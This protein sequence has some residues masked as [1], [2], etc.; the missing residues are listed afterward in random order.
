[1]F[2]FSDCHSVFSVSSVSS[3]NR[4]I[5]TYLSLAR[6][7]R[8]QSFN[9]LVGQER[10][11]KAL[12]SSLRLSRIPQALIFSGVRGVG[13][14]TLARLYAKALCC[15]S[16]PTPDPCG[17]CPNCLAIGNGSHGDVCEIDAASHNGVD[18]IRQLQDS[19]FYAP[20]RSAYRV[21]ILDEVHMLSLSAFNALLKTLEEP[22][23]HVVFIFATTDPH[24]IPDTILGRCQIFH[25]KKITPEAILGRV[26]DILGREGI[27]F[28]E[29]ALFPIA[30]KAQ[31]SMR[32]ALTFLDQAIALGGGEVRL[33]SVLEL[34]QGISS[35]I[36]M[37]WL[38]ELLEGQSQAALE[39]IQAWENEGQNLLPVTE[40]LLRMIRNSFILKNENPGGQ[41]LIS[42]TSKELT[43]LKALVEHQDPKR[44]RRMFQFFFPSL[45]DLEGSEYDRFILENLCLEWCFL[46]EDVIPAPQATLTPVVPP[47]LDPEPLEPREAPSQE[48]VYQEALE[49]LISK[50][51]EKKPL[52]AKLLEDVYPVLINTQ[53][54]QV[55]VKGDSLASKL[56][57]PEEQ[58]LMEGILQDVVGYRGRFRAIL[59]GSSGNETLSDRKIKDQKAEEIRVQEEFLKKPLVRTLMESFGGKITPKS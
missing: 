28:E 55:L 40:E 7:Y 50:L 38:K 16:G 27:A 14:T 11:A 23:S 32:D 54:I 58:T 18:E 20:Q 36:A 35:E 57:K 41:S 17:S 52:A 24:K 5:L 9:D 8:P 37:D 2:G 29:E 56:L 6:K 26:G 15:Q 43:Q 53:E 13:K 3:I 49:R 22:P 46:E 59:Q 1:M 21:F 4:R 30:R 25:L 12:G 44:L 47:A 42:L 45:K 31:G 10:A 39:R 34:C 51:K 19:I 33:K 48:R